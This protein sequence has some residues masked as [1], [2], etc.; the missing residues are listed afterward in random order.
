MF[1][2]QKLIFIISIITF[3]QHQRANGSHV[4]VT[5]AENLDFERQKV[6]EEG[7]VN[8]IENFGQHYLFFLGCHPNLFRLWS[9]SPLG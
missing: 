3:Q 1:V 9:I 4:E 5:K 7:K 6:R 8:R 2:K